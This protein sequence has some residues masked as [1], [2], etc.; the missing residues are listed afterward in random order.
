MAPSAVEEQQQA[1]AP[2]GEE[3]E[4][5]PAQIYNVKETRFEKYIEPDTSGRKKALERP[6][7]TAIVIDNGMLAA[8]APSRHCV[9]ISPANALFRILRRSSRL[10]V[11]IRPSI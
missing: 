10:V 6:D 1:S 2:Q 4:Y 7:S 9:A 3:K 5:L 8:S 11:R